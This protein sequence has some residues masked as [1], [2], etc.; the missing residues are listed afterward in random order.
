MERAGG[1]EP[2][3]RTLTS[4]ASGQAGEF[5]SELMAPRDLERD[6]RN[7]PWSCRRFQRLLQTANV[8]HEDPCGTQFGRPSDR[9][10]ADEAAVEVV[11]T[12]YLDRGQQARHRTRREYGGRH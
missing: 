7:L 11:L 3:G 2:L 4:T 9:Y 5:F 10:G 6:H 8:Q 12:A 1:V